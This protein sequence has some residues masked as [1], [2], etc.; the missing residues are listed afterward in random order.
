M[1]INQNKRDME[2]I[3]TEKASKAR[4]YIYSGKVFKEGVR[5]TAQEEAVEEPKKVEVE[6]SAEERG[7]RLES[8]REALF[9]GKLF[10]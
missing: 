10:K 8:A 1:C 3:D 5:D 2:R 4:E 6:G 9:N 7:K